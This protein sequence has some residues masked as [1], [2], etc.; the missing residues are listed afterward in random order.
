M[1][2]AALLNSQ[3]L[4][5]SDKHIR[6]HWQP[7][8]LLSLM[9]EG[10]SE[11]DAVSYSNKL[12]KGTRLFY[13]DFTQTNSL[14]SAEQFLR[15]IYNCTQAPQ[16]HD[17][18]FRFGQRLLPGYYG[19]LSHG[20]HSINQVDTLLEFIEQQAN[21]FSPLLKPVVKR[22]EEEIAV[23]FYPSY[24]PSI[25]SNQIQKRTHLV[26]CE[27]WMFAIKNWLQQQCGYTLPWRFEF[28]YDQPEAVE[29]YEVYLGENLA[30][31]RPITCMRLPKQAAFTSWQSDHAYKL[32]V[33]YATAHTQHP[34]TAQPMPLL[35]FVRQRLTENIQHNPSLEWV[36]NELNTS[37]AT[38]KRR[39]KSCNTQFRD[40]LSDIR[41]EVAVDIYQHRQFTNEQ[42]C[43]F[44]GFYDES[45][46]RRFFKR[47]TGQS[48]TQYFN[49]LVSRFVS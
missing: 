38:L 41:L 20:L 18:S 12:L 40:L 48:H 24:S 25:C 23:C 10:L 21:T 17:L 4:L 14:L 16:Q 11:H 26:L 19:D 44:L 37:P 2:N 15:F 28:N 49:L 3:L 36:A 22:Y 6:T 35:N 39:L 8:I 29:N 32:G 31:N 33:N 7:A 5:P 42:I 46:L 13:S 1:N 45:N 27:A 43:E 30:F 47:R 34:T 9:C